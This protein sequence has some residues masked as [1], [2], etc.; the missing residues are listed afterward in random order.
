MFPEYG[1]VAADNPAHGVHLRYR[2]VY[3]LDQHSRHFLLSGRLVNSTLSLS[4]ALCRFM[5]AMLCVFIFRRV[6][7]QRQCN[8]NQARKTPDNNSVY[9]VS[10]ARFNH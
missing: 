4:F 3:G 2:V 9:R 10:P 1:C 5:S 8:A 6:Q 7:V